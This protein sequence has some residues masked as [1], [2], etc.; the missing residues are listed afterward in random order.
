MDSPNSFGQALEQFLS[1]FVPPEGIKLL[2]YADDLLVAGPK[3]ED[4]RASTISLFLRRQRIKGLK[5]QATVY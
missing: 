1:Q 5:L 4:V 3:E 2:P